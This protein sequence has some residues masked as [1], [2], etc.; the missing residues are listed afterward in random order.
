MHLIIENVRDV[1][2]DRQS[3]DQ[4]TAKCWASINRSMKLWDDN[5][6]EDVMGLVRW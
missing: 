5:E 6:S 4:K 2:L 3:I 1:L